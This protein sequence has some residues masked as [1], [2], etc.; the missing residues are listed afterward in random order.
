MERCPKIVKVRCDGCRL[1]HKRCEEARPCVFCLEKEI[2]CTQTTRKGGQGTRVKA[3]CLP[4]RKSKLRCNGG[5]PCA[6]CTRRGLDCV[7]KPCPLCVESGRDVCHHR[8]KDDHEVQLDSQPLS[9]PEATSR[10]PQP[11]T[12]SPGQLF[13]SPFGGPPPPIPGLST[14]FLALPP[15]VSN[16]N[17]P[18]LQPLFAPHYSATFIHPGLSLPSPA[19]FLDPSLQS[20]PSPTPQDLN[21]A[22][23][24]FTVPASHHA[25]PGAMMQLPV[26]GM[27]PANTTTSGQSYENR[28]NP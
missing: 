18:P 28:Q 5:R 19:M 11:F 13:F 22:S 17:E 9:P 21:L 8:Q 25:L 1:N 14:P 6:A 7:E 24:M 15:F 2:E 27:N 20:L 23:L 12:T 4:C 26:T 10:S 3:A 16:A